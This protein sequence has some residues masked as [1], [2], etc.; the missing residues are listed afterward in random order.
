VL[1][2]VH[3]GAEWIQEQQQLNVVKLEFYLILA[4]LY[5]SRTYWEMTCRREGH[6][7]GEWLVSG[8]KLIAI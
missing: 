5:Y 4:F 2:T 8:L 6:N 3:S 7:L 1:S